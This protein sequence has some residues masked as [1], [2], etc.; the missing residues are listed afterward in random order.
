MRKLATAALAFSAAIFL[1]DYIFPRGWLIPAALLFAALGAALLLLHEKW[2]RPAVI[3]LLFFSLGL[4]EYDIYSRLTADRAAAYAGQTRTVTGTVL[5]YPDRY[6]SYCRLHIR[7]DTEDLPHFKAIVYDNKRKL[8]D[9]EPG[10]HVSFM[11][12]LNTADM[13]YGQ[14]YANYHVNGYFL[15]MSIKG[16]EVLDKGGFSLRY[17]PVRLHRFLCERVDRVFPE[18]CRTFIKALM[19]GE[20]Q[21]FYEDDALYVT[22]SRSG[23]MH[24]AAVSGLHISFLVGLLVFI[25]GSGRLSAI[26]S[27][28]LVWAFVLVTG[29]GNSALRA[30]FMQTLLLLAPILRRENDAVTSLSAVLALILAFSPFAARS[31]SLQLSFAAMAGVICFGERIYACLYGL[32]PERLHFRP[33]RYALGVAA[34]S[35]SVTV[36]TTPLTAVHFSYVPLLAILSNLACI[37]AVSLCFCFAWAAC[38]LSIIPA[39]GTAAG[40]LCAWLVR[41][42]L[43]C[44]GTVARLPYSVLYMKTWG[45]VAWVIVSYLL[46]FLGVMLRK[47]KYLR[48]LLP[49]G[50]SLTMLV[51][52]LARSEQYYRSNDFVSVLDVGQGQ[53][54]TAFAGD[55]TAV[56]DCGNINRLDDAGSIAG[57]YLYSC[58]RRGIDL[59]ILTHLHTDHADGAVR[60]MEMLPVD[61]LILPADD[62]DRDGLE[63]EILSCAERK[64]TQVIRLENNTETDCGRMHFEIYKLSD[65]GDKNERCLMIQLDI[66]G[67]GLLV[68]ADSPKKQERALVEKTDLGGTDILVVGHHGSKNASDE[69]LLKEVGGGIAVISV[70][71]NTY[72]HPAPQT[73]EALDKNGFQVRRTDLDKTVELRLENENGEKSRKR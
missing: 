24:V 73:L 40:G 62:D 2:L 32:V 22:M 20:K 8:E 4:L 60:L 53:C 31:V 42:I 33:V 61:T 10:D 66:D 46:L 12:K 49:V 25:M 58:G 19:L 64:G 41:Y 69:E 9:A 3:A 39:L 63:R 36:F 38:V 34:G 52:V 48:V 51:C 15:R 11:A 45:A 23:L 18:D 7:I 47:R 13:I 54:I 16:E 68:T 29:A 65:A 56:I 21:D 14:P 44:A 30:A 37:W 1:A 57:E 50:I 70:G 17:L 59:L 67:T 6:D 35:L 72:G 26:F 43:F 28:L 27:I 71:Y 5:D 55:V